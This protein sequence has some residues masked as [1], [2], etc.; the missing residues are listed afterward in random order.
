MLEVLVRWAAAQLCI[1]SLSLYFSKG[2][3]H[4]LC[5]WVGRKEASATPAPMCQIRFST[6]CFPQWSCSNLPEVLCVDASALPLLPVYFALF[7]AFVLTLLLRKI[8]VYV[9][10][11]A[12]SFQAPG[13]YAVNYK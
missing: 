1:K 4:Q 8:P 7:R 6:G 12:V 9:Q 3:G 13:C 2:M 11:L 10:N 5:H